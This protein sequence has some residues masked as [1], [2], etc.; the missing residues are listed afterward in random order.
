[1]TRPT[2]VALVLVWPALGLGVSGC[3]SNQPQSSA[4]AGSPASTAG[5]AGIASTGG[6]GQS[7]LSGTGGLA[8]GGALPE[9]GSSSAA[10]GTVG[11]SGAGGSLPAATC[12]FQVTA[13]S[14]D[15][16]GAGGIP[17][18]G[19]V[20]WSVDLPNVTSAKI[21]FGLQGGTTMMTAP[22]DVK[23]G[24][25]FR[26]LLL[27]MKGSKTYAFHVEV[28]NGSNTCSSAESTVQTG[29]VSN[30]VPRITRMAG[31]SAVPAQKGFLIWS[32]GVG[33]GGGMGGGAGMAFI[34]DADGDPVWW[35]TAPAQCS[36]AKMSYD[37]QYMWMIGVNVGNQMKDGGEVARV[38]MDG[39]TKASKIPGLS[40]C[41]HDLTVL[42]DGKIACMSWIA[43][44]GDQPSDLIE[45]DAQG[46]VTKVMTLDSNVY[47]GGS[48]MGGGNTY[49]ANAIHYMQSDNTYTIGDRNPNAFLK[50]SRAGA[51]LWQ[52][53]GSCTGAKAPK[54]VP[55]DWK[56]NHG[57]QLL[58]DGSGTFLFFN[59][60]QSGAST[61]FEYK[62]TETGTFT[63]TKSWSYS[64]GTSSN[65][66][67]DVQRLPGGNTLV[68]FSVAGVIHELDPSQALVQSTSASAGGYVEWRET[69]YGPPPRF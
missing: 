14:A 67:G 9:G 69:L 15:K 59:N 22:V 68:S 33:M 2:A 57:H 1:M 60:G 43:Q 18:V 39:L 34:L 38:S 62:L 30:T 19:I 4:G 47:A 58:D 32:S 27:G 52:F 28:S 26:T 3:S 46:N 17:T 21:V 66:L 40:N 25:N 49:H 65:V 51:V 54:C 8:S 61:A 64:P 20:D 45:A 7:G 36:R 10:A 13:Q 11:T 16:A 55:G 31:T 41:H 23:T 35:T 12:T 5:T 42:P 50:V 53:G 48:G 56:V 44:S 24:P 37:G 63:A 6:T 29:A